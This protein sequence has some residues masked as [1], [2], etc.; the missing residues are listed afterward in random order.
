MSAAPC[1]ILSPPWSLALVTPPQDR[2][3]PR[4]QPTD[5]SPHGLASACDEILVKMSDFQRGQSAMRGDIAEVRTKLVVQGHDIDQLKA[6]HAE[7]KVEVGELGDRV[8]DLERLK[9]ARPPYPSRPQLPLLEDDEELEQTSPGGNYRIPKEKLASE[10]HRV[11]AMERTLDGLREEL[12]GAERARVI[13]KER[14]DAV[15]K[16]RL[17][18]AAEAKQKATEA[19]AKSNA[20][21]AKIKKWIG[22]TISAGP[23]GVGLWEAA[24]W[25]L[26]HVFH[27]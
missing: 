10:R 7:L 24:K 17:R 1:L 14:A 8:V 16:E 3:P 2:P 13:E 18:V 20:D 4:R 22:Y 26:V 27:F 11:A 12:D 9:H 15:E 19:A 23:V 5:P 25:L 6:G 21:D